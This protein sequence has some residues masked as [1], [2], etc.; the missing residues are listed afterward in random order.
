MSGHSS[1]FAIIAAANINGQ[2]LAF[3]SIM[4]IQHRIGGILAAALLVLAGWLWFAQTQPHAPEI[5]FKTLEGKELALSSLRGKPVLVT[6][7]ATDCPGCIEEIPHLIALHQQFHDRGLTIIAV[8]MHYDPPHHVIAL[9]EA[10]QLPYTV[11]L[12]LEATHARAFG[13]VRLTPTSFLIDLQG[14]IVAQ[15]TGVFDLTDMQQRLQQLLS[16]TD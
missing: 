10:K 5:T 9:T 4:K 7:W 1:S 6:F 2:F 12:D 11:V 15:K 16:T 14:K 8:A 13:N 3:R